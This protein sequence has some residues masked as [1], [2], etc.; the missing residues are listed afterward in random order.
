MRSH[1]KNFCN[2]V[3]FSSQPRF[4]SVETSLAVG[5]LSCNKVFAFTEKQAVGLGP[6]TKYFKPGQKFFPVADAK[7][8]DSRVLVPMDQHIRRVLAPVVRIRT[9]RIRWLFPTVQPLKSG[10]F[11]SSNQHSFE[12]SWRQGRGGPESCKQRCSKMRRDHALL[13]SSAH[14]TNAF[15]R[16]P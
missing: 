14:F 1:S 15:L 10:I 7:P 9:F 16:P 13:S 8:L 4:V 2:S 11:I 12:R 3:T 6:E 5:L